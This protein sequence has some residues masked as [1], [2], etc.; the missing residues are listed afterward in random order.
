MI[1]CHGEKGRIMGL[2]ATEQE[3]KDI[4]FVHRI[5]IAGG[6]VGQ[7]QPR[8]RQQGTADRSPL[9]LTLRQI[10]CLAFQFVSNSHF[11]GQLSSSITHGTV[12]QKG[13]G[14]PVRMKDVVQ[15]IQV[16][17]KLEILKYEA[18]GPYP[19]VPTIIIS[20]GMDLDLGDPH[21]APFRQEN[22]GDQ[23]QQCRFS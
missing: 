4:A 13:V 3:I 10:I 5:E 19:K 16:V 12:K 22:T 17:Q 14:Y 9:F 2:D 1:M 20:K 21:S 6:F 15:H 18:Y 7:D 8:L 11:R 23:I